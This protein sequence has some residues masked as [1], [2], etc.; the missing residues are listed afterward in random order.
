MGNANRIAPG[1]TK[2]INGQYLTE[3]ECFLENQNLIWYCVHKHKQVLNQTATD[4]WDLFSEGSIGLMKA[5][6]NFDDSTGYQFATYAV[7]KIH[8]EINRYVR[9]KAYTIRTPRNKENVIHASFNWTIGE[10]L[11]L[12][13]LF[14]QD[15]N[16]TTIYLNERLEQMNPRTRDMIKLRL[17]GYTQQEIADRFKLSQVQVCRIIN[18]E[19]AV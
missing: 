9:D 13:S 15:D 1:D 4:K 17:Q 7:P 14:G 11:E 6:R 5:Y 8:G 16:Y 3:E 10:G 18:G 2:L 12:E 19:V